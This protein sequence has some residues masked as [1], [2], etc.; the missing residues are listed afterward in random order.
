MCHLGKRAAAQLG[1]NASREV[2]MRDGVGGGRARGCRSRGTIAANRRPEPAK[3]T[4]CLRA[5]GN[6][7]RIR[8][9][10][11]S[12]EVTRLAITP[13]S[14]GGVEGGGF[15][16]GAGP[17]TAGGP[18]RPASTPRARRAAAARRG[19]SFAE[20]RRTRG[21]VGGKLCCGVASET[22]SRIRGMEE[23]DLVV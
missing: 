13:R 17:H 8:P 5:P 20:R 15:H 11:P 16:R 14:G 10:R 2:R 1:A 21:A 9:Q 7:H 12:E 22:G 3:Q 6:I 19:E 18:T 23:C 4:L